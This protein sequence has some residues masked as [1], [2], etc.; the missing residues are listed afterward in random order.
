MKL[1]V[2]IML[3]LSA[4]GLTMSQTRDNGA[5]ASRNVPGFER[6]GNL[7]NVVEGENRCLCGN[8][9]MV[10][11]A[12]QKVAAGDVIETG[13]GRTEIL[14]KPGYFLRLSNQTIARLLDL[15]PSNLKIELAK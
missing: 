9:P 15:S 11:S 14:L 5:A 1:L 4:P 7:I 10:L 2:S 6:T 12:G 13:A 3:A 8:R